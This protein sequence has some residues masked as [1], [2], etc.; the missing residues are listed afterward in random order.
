M[1][2]IVYIKTNTK[3]L[4]IMLII[5]DC[6]HFVKSLHMHVWYC[7]TKL[8]ARAL[9]HIKI[10]L[11]CQCSGHTLHTTSTW[12]TWLSPQKDMDYWNHVLGSDESK[13]NQF[14]SDSLK[15]VWQQL[16]E[17]YKDKCAVPTHK[18]CDGLHE[19]SKCW[20]DTFN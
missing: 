10:L 4:C 1:T 13:I 17:E 5:F 8:S 18:Y 12:S 11:A 7:P 3:T 6:F 20:G 19:Y 9:H 16:G 14:G 15:H 2:I